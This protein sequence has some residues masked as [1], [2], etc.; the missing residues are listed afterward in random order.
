MS[1]RR[2]LAIVLVLIGLGGCAAPQEK[3]ADP[4]LRMVCAIVATGEARFEGVEQRFP[5]MRLICEKEGGGR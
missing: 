1:A 5:S 3:T 4:Y 2:G